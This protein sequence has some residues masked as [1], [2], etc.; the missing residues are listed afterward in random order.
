M[1]EKYVKNFRSVSWSSA[2]FLLMNR[3][4]AT[5]IAQPNNVNVAIVTLRHEWDYEEHDWEWDL[6]LEYSSAKTLGW[7]SRGRL[8]TGA[9]APTRSTSSRD[10]YGGSSQWRCFRSDE[11]RHPL[12]RH[13]RERTFLTR[14]KNNTT[15]IFKHELVRGKT[16]YHAKHNPRVH[17]RV[18]DATIYSV[19]FGE[20][21]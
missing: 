11:W 10:V 1:S 13:S 4:M 17:E 21:T 15:L 12:Q 6:P 14:P 18:S 5:C 20:A 9:G 16:A 8:P 19:S 2:H 3:N 7:S